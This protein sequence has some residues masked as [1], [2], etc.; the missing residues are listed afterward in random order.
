MVNNNFKGKLCLIS[1]LTEKDQLA[2]I[3]FR[4]KEQEK[5]LTNL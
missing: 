5:H 3:K 4:G 2:I 1:V